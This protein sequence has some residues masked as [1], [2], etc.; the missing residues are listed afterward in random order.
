MYLVI[1]EWIL[2]DT[3]HIV[4]LIVAGYYRYKDKNW[5]NVFTIIKHKRVMIQLLVITSVRTYV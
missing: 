5:K 4:V 1:L 2:L 3:L